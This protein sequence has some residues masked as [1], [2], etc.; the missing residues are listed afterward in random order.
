MENKIPCNVC[1][2]LVLPATAA[3]TD[4]QCM[5]CFK[6]KRRP[7][8]LSSSSGE[9]GDQTQDLYVVNITGENLKPTDQA[10]KTAILAEDLTRAS[11]EFS[12]NVPQP[13]TSAEDAKQKAAQVVLTDPQLKALTTNAPD[14]PIR[15]ISAEAA[16]AE[17]RFG[18]NGGLPYF[19]YSDA[20]QFDTNMPSLDA[21]TEPGGEPFRNL[22]DGEPDHK[23]YKECLRRTKQGDAEAMEAL[24]SH[25]AEA[26]E[27]SLVSFED[28]QH[29]A[30]ELTK[31]GESL[32]AAMLAEVLADPDSKYHE[33]GRAYFW[34][35]LAYYL[36]DYTTEYRD[37]GAGGAVYCG[38]TGDFRNEA[39][40]SELVEQLGR[41]KVQ[42]L[43]QE[44]QE[45]LKVNA[46]HR[47]D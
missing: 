44:A 38:A 5:P 1:G 3:K 16:K 13:A 7:E 39:A 41:D 23:A 18:N 33:P 21:L 30:V 32:G 27:D 19:I 2:A 40:V 15:I 6:G 11:Y 45:W 24:L 8:S 36:D 20:E 37:T 42:H 35:F 28:F 12:V 14:D 9:V 31:K 25:F 29:F 34:Y 10:R 43:D 4:G 17:V 26:E 22:A 46:L 47:L